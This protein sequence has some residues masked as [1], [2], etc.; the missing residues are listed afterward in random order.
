MDLWANGAG[1]YTP[2]V[3]PLFTGPTFHREYE[4]MQ[5]ITAQLYIVWEQMVTL[6]LSACNCNNHNKVEISFAV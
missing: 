3:L 2:Y 1:V 4:K 5:H 6:W